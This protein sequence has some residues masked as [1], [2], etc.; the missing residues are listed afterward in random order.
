MDLNSGVAMP[1]RN[2]MIFLLISWMLSSFSFA[3]MCSWVDEEGVRHFSNTSDCKRGESSMS[4]EAGD[5]GVQAAGTRDGLRFTGVY[6][7]GLH[8]IRF[9]GDG[10]VVSALSPEKPEKLAAWFGKSAKR[11][12]IGNYAI[13][14]GQFRFFARCGQKLLMAE[15]FVKDDGIVIAILDNRGNPRRE[16]SLVDSGFRYYMFIPVAFPP[17]NR[18]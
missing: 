10:T 4:P 6:R 7:Y 8:Y 15:G 12:Y 17:R 18:N 16:R 14:A 11:A 13:S 5:R 3:D 2:T 1:I 9:Y